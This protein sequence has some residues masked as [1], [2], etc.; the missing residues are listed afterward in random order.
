[1]GNS[2]R[3]ADAIKRIVK[4]L[5][6]EQQKG[7]DLDNAAKSPISGSRGIGYFAN[8][9]VQGA[10]GAAGITQAS[11]KTDQSTKNASDKAADATSEAAK[12]VLGAVDGI[13][14][15]YDAQDL[16]DKITGPISPGS[17]LDEA[18]EG[19]LSSAKSGIGSSRLM[20]ITGLQA[21]DNF[22]VKWPI[23]VR[24]DGNYSPPSGWLTSD[25]PPDDG[26]SANYFWTAVTFAGTYSGATLYEVGDRAAQALLSYSSPLFT[27]TSTRFI[28]TTYTP[29]D[30]SA[31]YEIE[32]YAEWNP[33]NEINTGWVPLNIGCNRASCSG[34][35]NPSIYC[36]TSAPLISWPSQGVG[37]L[38]R[39]PNTGLFVSDNRDNELPV[40][41]R[42]ERSTLS[43]ETLTG[44]PIEFT[45]LRNGGF[46]YYQTSGGSPTGDIQVYDNNG[47]FLGYT[48]TAGL[49]RL[50]PQ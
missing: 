13:Q 4:P 49:T 5:F 28:S 39:D 31:D 26:W 48:D 17:G 23:K 45:I 44:T 8:G 1:L 47:F 34:P 7:D 36:L 10:K 30:A 16:I 11:A 42:T 35:G 12:N 46:A 22:G 37:Q 40:T 15:S 50:K 18:L 2:N 21:T 32:Y 41:V 43:L 38:T 33:P 14:G 27:I 19:A 3:Y 25:T 24:T 29:G 9:A 20:E 6:D